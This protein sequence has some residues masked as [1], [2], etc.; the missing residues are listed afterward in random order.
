MLMMLAMNITIRQLQIFESV[1][2]NLSYT[3]A[4]EVLYLSQ[5]AVSM[6]IKQLESEL[7]MPLFERMGKTLY[8]TNAGVELLNYAGTIS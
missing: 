4:A 6:Q 2:K 7:D 3:R 1:A 8:L 5:P